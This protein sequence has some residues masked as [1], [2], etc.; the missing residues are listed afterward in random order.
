MW[1]AGIGGGG[2]MVV[3]SSNGSFDYIDFRDAAPSAAFQDMFNDKVNSSLIGGLASGVPGELRG[4][5]LL[6]HRHGSLP[7]HKLVEPAIRVAQ[8]GF[9]VTD[10][11]VHAMDSITA[12]WGNFLVK[13]PAWAVD[14]APNGTLV[15]LGDTLTRKRYANTLRTIARDGPGVFYRGPMAKSTVAA[16]RAQNGIMSERDLENYTAILRTPLSATY[17]DY[18]LTTGSAPSGGSIA[19]SALKIIEGYPVSSNATWSNLSAHRLDEAFRFA[20]GQRPKLGDP[21]FLPDVSEYERHIT[22]S[23]TATL[24]R[25]QIS[26]DHT[27]DIS[28]Y[29][30]DNYE[31]PLSAGTSHITTMDGS[32]MAVSLTTAINKYFGS[33]LIVPSTGII[34]NNVMNDFSIPNNSNNNYR[35]APANF[36]QPGKRPLSSNVPLIVEFQANGTLVLALGAAGGLHIITATV[37]ATLGV[38]DS[39]LDVAAALARPR[40]HDQLQ[41]NRIELDWGFDNATAA[42]LRARGHTV[43]WTKPGRSLVMAVRRLPNGTLEAAADPNTSEG[44][45]LTI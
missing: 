37:E 22:D 12:L 24:I 42:G 20:Y 31:A 45:G 6:H 39:G 38:L 32:G 7:W 5:E 17:R 26:D 28:A 16:L 40:F 4:L 30:P 41:P 13:D 11:L 25:D 2:F 29:N 3:R 14:F 10:D 19:L 23:Q 27:L 1:H 33:K 9:P 18:K 8:R 44:G 21:S 34:L 15:G 35:L 36:I 43:A